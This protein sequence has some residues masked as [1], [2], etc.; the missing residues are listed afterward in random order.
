MA[1]GRG[2]GALREAV[3]S[4]HFPD[5]ERWQDAPAGM[6]MKRCMKVTPGAAVCGS[7]A[8]DFPGWTVVQLFLI[9]R[10]GFRIS[11][12]GFLSICD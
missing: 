9:N 11:P 8:S 2:F 7:V 4:I 12:R 3:C 10:F 6:C 1:G 5:Y